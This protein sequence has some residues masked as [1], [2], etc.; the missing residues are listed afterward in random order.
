MKEWEEDKKEKQA[1]LCLPP[2]S[3]SIEYT[4]CPALDPCARD[5]RTIAP[6]MSLSASQRPGRRGP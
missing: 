1:K 6:H 5:G 2:V 3:L 4:K